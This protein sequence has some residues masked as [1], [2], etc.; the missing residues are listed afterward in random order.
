MQIDFYA[1]GMGALGSFLQE[2]AYWY[3]LKEH[4]AENKYRLMYRSTMYWVVLLAMVTGAGFGTWAWFEPQVQT[5]RTY[6]LCGAA[7][8]LLLK[9]FVSA[10]VGSQT[11]LG[12]QE[13]AKS[14]ALV[15]LRTYITGR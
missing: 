4:L 7:F 6:V 3:D 14:S 11:T 15:S 5:G 2:I 10:F 8:P 1:V 13:Q 12:V 9:K